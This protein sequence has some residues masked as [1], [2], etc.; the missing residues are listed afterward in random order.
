MY[1]F[2]MNYYEEINKAESGNLDAMFNVA[3][4]IIWG[5]RK[6]VLEPELAERAI[7]YYVENAKAGDTDSMLDLGAV[8][9][10]GRGVEKD[11]EKALEWYNRAAELGAKKAYRC[12]GN[13]YLYDNLNDGSPVPTSEEDRL[14]E[15]YKWYSIGAKYKEENS[16]F[17]LGDFFRY[18]ICVEQNNRKAFELY[19]EA[20]DSIT[21]S[22]PEAEW[23][24]NDSY[25]DVC[26]RLAECYH[27]GIGTEINLLAAE[28]YIQIAKEE[29]KCRFDEGDMY[30]GSSLQRAEKEWIAI[31]QDVEYG[32][33]DIIGKKTDKLRR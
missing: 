20:Y 32:C 9:L 5:D 14:K 8:Y 16:L 17:E 18:G 21:F 7:R 26:L 11:P 15:A 22:V 23:S 33:E 29:C 24:Y 27:Y 31:F 2:S 30:G 4:Y 19:M 12:L 13:F 25:S 6:S 1:P 10:D 3:S 28:K